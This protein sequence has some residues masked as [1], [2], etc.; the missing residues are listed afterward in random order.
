[1][2]L[3][4]STS[5]FVFASTV[6]PFASRDCIVAAKRGKC[7]FDKMTEPPIDCLAQRIK[8]KIG[9]LV[10]ECGHQRPCCP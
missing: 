9:R 2:C 5:T 3:I 6:K 7:R 10:G 4:L 1:M 8:D